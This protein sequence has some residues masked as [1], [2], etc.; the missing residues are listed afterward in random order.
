MRSEAIAQCSSTSLHVGPQ[1][2]SL[3]MVAPLADILDVGMQQGLEQQRA[4]T[5]F[6]SPLSTEMYAEFYA[7][8]KR[9]STM[10]AAAIKWLTT[11]LP[12]RLPALSQ[13]SGGAD[14]GSPVIAEP[15][16]FRV[17]SIGSGSGELDLEVLQ[18]LRARL[19]PRRPLIY[20]A[21]EP[22][23][24]HYNECL[25]ALGPFSGHDATT[26]EVLPLP[27][28]APGGFASQERYDL[29]LFI[30][31]LYYFPKLIDCLAHALGMLAPSGRVVIVHQTEVGIPELQEAHM[32]DLRGNREQILTTA[33]VRSQMHEAGLRHDYEEVEAHLD[34]SE[35]L[36]GSEDGLKIL[37][38]CME[39]DLRSLDEAR[40]DGLLASLRARVQL[41]PAGAAQLREP[42]GLFIVKSQPGLF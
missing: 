29:V 37:S 19:S 32:M 30:H 27:F 4:N 9:A 35:C 31:V 40:R 16:P 33:Q 22:N 6:A 2:G 17:L 23:P 25:H 11:E 3:L 20:Q 39:C 5:A 15:T 21:L 38:F 34:V 42:I 26:V 41:S 13:D 10:T 28:A 18:M 36:R 8:R 14:S 24:V 1:R 7:L 12:A